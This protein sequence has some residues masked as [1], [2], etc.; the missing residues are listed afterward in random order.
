MKRSEDDEEGVLVFDASSGQARS[1]AP[2][3]GVS[4]VTIVALETFPGRT[5]RDNG[6]GKAFCAGIGG[7][8]QNHHT[9]A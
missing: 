3:L 9:G 2:P 7:Q 4:I 1:R 5:A 8:F 6:R